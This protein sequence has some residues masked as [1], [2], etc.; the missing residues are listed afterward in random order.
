MTKLI[1]ELSDI[2]TALTCGGEY[3]EPGNPGCSDPNEP[4]GMP[5]PGP[6]G[7]P[8]LGPSRPDN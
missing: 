1:R 6:G 5:V 2:E 4:I 7:L 8:D 3:S